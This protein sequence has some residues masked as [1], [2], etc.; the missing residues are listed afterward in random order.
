[1]GDAPIVADDGDGAGV[2]FPAGGFLCAFCRLK[3]EGSR[4]RREGENENLQMEFV[5]HWEL[6]VTLLDIS[7]RYAQWIFLQYTRSKTLP[8]TSNTLAKR[9][10]TARDHVIILLSPSL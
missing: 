8:E 9:G 4:N 2:L 7:S 3:S 5:C 10:P 1:M 6:S